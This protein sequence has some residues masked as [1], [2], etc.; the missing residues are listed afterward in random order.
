MIKPRSAAP[1]ARRRDDPR[2]GGI[3]V[4]ALLF[5]FLGASLVGAFL[6][7]ATNEARLSRRALDYQKAR[8]AAEA[9][10]DYGVLQLR[11]LILRHQL[12]LPRATLQNQLDALPPPPAFPGYVYTTTDGTATFRLRVEND[13]ALDTVI[14]NGTQCRGLIG[15]SQTYTV[16]VGA[17]NPAS[18]V[19]AVLRLRLHAVGVF[20]IRYA[21]FYE[22]DCEILPGP[23]MTITGPVHCNSDLY[24][25]AN[26][27]L[28]FDDRVTSVS[29]ILNRRKDNTSVPG[30][31]VRILNT[32]GASEPMKRGTHILDS[33]YDQW[34]SESL[35]VWTGR[36]L[37]GA[38]GMQALRP[39]IAPVDTPRDIIERPL[40]TNAPAYQA[41]TETEKFA[42][43]ASLR[44]HVDAA[45]N[46]SATNFY[47][48]AV[49]LGLTQPVTNGAYGG[50]PPYDKA[51]RG[52]YSLSGAGAVDTTQTNLY[53]AREERYV[54]PVDIYVDRLVPII[55]SLGYGTTEN[56]GL[57]YVTREPTPDGRMP[58]VRLRNGHE[59]ALPEG[60]SIVSDLPVYIEG[61]YNVT[62][63]KT[64][65]VAGDAVTMLSQNWQDARSI[66]ALNQ[67]SVIR[68]TNNC[69]IM[70]GNTETRSGAYNGGVENV[71]RF[72]EN[73]N[74]Q[75]YVY[76]GSIIDLWYSR[77]ATGAWVYGNN[78][79]TAPTRD[80]GYDDI[81]RTSN[82]PGMTR[83]FGLEEIAWEELSWREAIW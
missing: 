70:T 3:V 60:L 81:Y 72:L 62:D 55:D 63:P 7:Y 10:L 61:Q 23:N 1:P 67:R 73:W 6:Q 78:R 71:L 53:D 4:V 44:I 20:L 41:D 18:D 12:R 8:I 65:M 2:G 40:A 19:G 48:G 15:D 57:V 64:A 56:N 5:S 51:N 13:V 27:S 66:A 36:A 50:R 24:L 74:G 25:G 31:H 38:H 39:P 22:N 29:R 76:R 49:A 16:T 75:R 28:R 35:E 9:G 34:I 17:R 82:P 80:W 58:A 68:T 42:N 21:I 37:S 45:G 46:V 43:K 47:G 52:R 79:Y 59:I 32:L 14:T 69:V 26:N 33:N 77:T 11:N 83:V 54:A 30:G